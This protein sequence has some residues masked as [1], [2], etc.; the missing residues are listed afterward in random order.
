MRLTKSNVLLYAMILLV[1]FCSFAGCVNNIIEGAEIGI[2]PDG[3]KCDMPQLPKIASFSGEKYED[4]H[5]H[6]P[7]VESAT[8]RS[9]ETIVSIE[10][11]DPRL[12]RLLNF[13]AYGI[14]EGHTSWRQG[15]VLE[16]EINSYLLCKDTMLDII[17]RPMEEP[18]NDTHAKTRRMIVCGDSYLLFVASDSEGNIRGERFWPYAEL[19]LTQ[20]SSLLSN[21]WGN[22]YWIDMLTFAGFTQSDQ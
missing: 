4:Y 1:I 12:V 17:F 21:E 11:S 10:P 22:K 14:N 6:F 3:L 13:L 20:D 7:P 2:V 9:N 18:I 19:V 5:I 15:Y 8:L 16:N